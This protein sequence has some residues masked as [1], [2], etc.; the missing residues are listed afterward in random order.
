[1]SDYY[2]LSP[3]DITGKKRDLKTS[4]ARHVAMYL[5]RQQ[6]HTNLSQ[7]GKILGNRDHSTVVHGCEKITAAIATDS[8]LSKSIEDIRLLLKS[9]GAN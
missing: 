4:H 7:I 6:N 8:Q 2:G 3:D 9:H 1:V 5:L